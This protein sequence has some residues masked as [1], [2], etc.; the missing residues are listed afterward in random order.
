MEPM[1]VSN[2]TEYIKAR[3]VY[4]DN[5]DNNFFD[6]DTAKGLKIIKEVDRFITYYLYNGTSR[7]DT[8]KNLSSLCFNEEQ[9]KELTDFFMNHRPG[10]LYDIEQG[11][12]FLHSQ[13][14]KEPDRYTSLIHIQKGTERIRVQDPVDVFGESDVAAYR[15]AQVAAHNRSYIT[16]FSQSVVLALDSSKVVAFDRCHIIARNMPIIAAYNSAVLDASDQAVIIAR[17]SSKVTARHNS[18]VLLQDWATCNASDTVMVI[19]RSQNK[20]KL[21]K[22]NLRLLLGHPFINGNPE[23]ALNLLIASADPNDIALFQKRPLDMGCL[24]P[25]STK[26]V[27]Q[28]IAKKATSCR[29]KR[30]ERGPPMGTM[31]GARGEFAYNGVIPEHPL[32]RFPRKPGSYRP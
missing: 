23:A 13:N 24:D 20:P 19:T 32:P 14:S 6:I 5:P 4:R 18:L 29:A 31:I 1:L 30:E 25:E 3:N 11:L 15:A 16:A 17:G 21:L 27:L 22:D 28:S 9:A 10:D 7:E 12:N 26:E 8:E 2:Q